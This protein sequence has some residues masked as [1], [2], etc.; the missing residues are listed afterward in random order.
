LHRCIPCH[1]VLFCSLLRLLAAAECI[2]S[3]SNNSNILDFLESP[4]IVNVSQ[5]AFL[6]IGHKCV[7]SCEG[8]TTTIGN[9]Q[10]SYGVCN[11]S[12]TP[13]RGSHIL[14]MSSLPAC[15]QPRVQVDAGSAYCRTEFSCC[16]GHHV[17]VRATVSVY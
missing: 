9:D 12:A 11:V 6:R 4:P 7:A 16:A 5:E 8:V 3:F 15:D 2:E 13:A 17:R 14:A 10:V 1:S